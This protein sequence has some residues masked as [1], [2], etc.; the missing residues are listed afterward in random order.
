MDFSFPFFPPFERRKPVPTSSYI[1]RDYSYSVDFSSSAGKYEARIPWRTP[2]E[3]VMGS[4]GNISR[5]SVQVLRRRQSQSPA[6]SG[7]DLPLATPGLDLPLATPG[8]DL[9]PAIPG[10]DLPLATPGLDLPS[11]EGQLTAASTLAVVGR[12]HIMGI[13]TTE[14]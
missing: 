9:P 5:R 1:S 12:D 14:S 4:L 10:L 2:P 6:T 11:R 3:Y 7:L 13:S 8:L